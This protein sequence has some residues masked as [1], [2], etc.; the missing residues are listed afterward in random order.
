MFNL[1]MLRTFSLFSLILYSFNFFLSV[2]NNISVQ[3][4]ML[5]LC[6]HWIGGIWGWGAN[7]FTLAFTNVWRNPQSHNVDINRWTGQVG[8]STRRSAQISND[9]LLWPFLFLGS[10]SRN[11]MRNDCFSKVSICP[12]LDSNSPVTDTSSCLNPSFIASSPSFSQNKTKKYHRINLIGSITMKYMSLQRHLM[13]FLFPHLWYSKSL[14]PFLCQLQLDDNDVDNH[15]NQNSSNNNTKFNCLDIP[16]DTCRTLN[17]GQLC[18]M[19]L[20]FRRLPK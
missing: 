5:P 18:N 1:N 14:W 12:L 16:A 2:G 20:Q 7:V 9:F 8:S 3:I 13:F 10:D 17:R 15:N 11:A 4:S 6:Y 19:R